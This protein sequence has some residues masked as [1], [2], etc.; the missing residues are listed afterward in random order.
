MLLESDIKWQLSFSVS[1]FSLQ[2][3]PLRWKRRHISLLHIFS[4]KSF[5]CD[6]HEPKKERGISML[7]LRFHVRIRSSMVLAVGLSWSC[8]KDS[9]EISFFLL[10]AKSML[11]AVVNESEFNYRIE[12]VWGKWH[13][14]DSRIPRWKI[15]GSWAHCCYGETIEKLSHKKERKNPNTKEGKLND[16]KF[17]S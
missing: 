15:L 6:Y 2:I 14:C 1:L 9:N 4:R 11:I 5:I 13:A 17:R 16:N 8:A 7:V 10:H 12:F 3:R